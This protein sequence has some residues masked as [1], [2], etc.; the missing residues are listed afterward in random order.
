MRWVPK[1]VKI[2]GIF[3]GILQFMRIFLSI[4]IFKDEIIKS[5]LL[6]PLTLKRDYFALKRL[7]IF[8]F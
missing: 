1:Q 4:F 7:G 8:N 5:H 3:H 2:F 6:S